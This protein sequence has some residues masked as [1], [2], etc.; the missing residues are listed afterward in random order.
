MLSLNLLF[1]FIFGASCL[2]GS[3]GCY[4]LKLK[5][6]K[7]LN[8]SLNP[9]SIDLKEI[10]GLASDAL[11]NKGAVDVETVEELEGESILSGNEA[12][13][14][15]FIPAPPI[16]WVKPLP[17]VTIRGKEPLKPKSFVESK[18]FW[19]IGGAVAFVAGLLAYFLVFA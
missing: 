18:L 9:N 1:L 17:Y 19:V 7:S 10:K 15:P 16:G 4:R 3:V 14:P 5:L 13:A 11:H 6:I 8:Q 2:V 12:L